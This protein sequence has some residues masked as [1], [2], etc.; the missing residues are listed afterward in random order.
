MARVRATVRYFGPCRLQTGRDWDAVELP[1]PATVA[2]LLEACC[3]L[4]P[5]LQAAR[6]SLL[7]A[8]DQ[9]FAG[10]DTVLT[11][12]EEIA[13]MPPLSGGA[14]AVTL[15]RGAISVRPLADALLGRGEG[16]LSTFEGIVRPEGPAAEHGHLDYD[17]YGPMAEKKLAQVADEARRRF[18]VLDIAIAHRHGP[19]PVGEVAV[20]IAVT[21][22]H[23][24]AA[25]EAC[26]FAI[27]R[28]KEI[29]PIWKMG[30][31]ACQHGAPPLSLA[32]TF[33]TSGSPPGAPAQPPSG[34]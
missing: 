1:Q 30:G 12:G 6:R 33:P 3:R 9:E 2:D 8:V 17:A 16:A 24:K 27:A 34:A 18:D 23:R 28:I 31:D 4:H 26:A 32:G 15:T 20:A 22:Q 21:A 10:A 13:L 5:A 7:V 11:G 14:G 25:F 29:V 19:V